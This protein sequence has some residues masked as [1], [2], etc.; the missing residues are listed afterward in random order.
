MDTDGHW[1]LLSPLDSNC[2]L[3]SAQLTSHACPLQVVGRESTSTHTSWTRTDF[4]GS[5]KFKT[6]IFLV[7][8]LVFPHTNLTLVNQNVANF[9]SF[10]KQLNTIFW[11]EMLWQRHC[12]KQLG[13]SEGHHHLEILSTFP[14]AV[15]ASEMQQ[16]KDKIEHSLSTNPKQRWSRVEGDLAG[17]SN[18]VE[19]HQ[20][21]LSLFSRETQRHQTIICQM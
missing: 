11:R 20:S 19:T 17:C 21:I 7:A 13:S 8:W 18:L 9:R 4:C 1:C 16:N 10:R 12:G 15:F 3:Y 2:T 6:C 14:Q 5:L